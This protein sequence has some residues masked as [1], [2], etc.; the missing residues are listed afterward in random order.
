MKWKD[1]TSAGFF[2]FCFYHF[3]SLQQNELF[4]LVANPVFWIKV[5][6]SIAM[7]LIF[8][9]LFQKFKKKKGN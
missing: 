9:F 6:I 5:S 2:A 3:L 1:L 8:V 7:G 4:H